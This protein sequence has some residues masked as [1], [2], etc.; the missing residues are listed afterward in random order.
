MCSTLSFLIIPTP[1]MQSSQPSRILR[2]SHAFHSQLTLTRIQACS[3]RIL[4]ESHTFHTQLTCFSR[5]LAR[6]VSVPGLLGN[7]PVRVA[8]SLVSCMSRSPA[9][10][11]GPGHAQRIYRAYTYRIPYMPRIYTV[12]M[13]QCIT[14]TVSW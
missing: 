5:K 2:E 6:F 11:G 4:L 14:C 10:R 1:Q 3:S 13:R 9:R 8:K 7:D 12:L